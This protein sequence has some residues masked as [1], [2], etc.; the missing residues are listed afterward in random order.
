MWYWYMF[1]DIEVV[2][3]ARANVN[4]AHN[5]QK[6]EPTPPIHMMCLIQYLTEK[7]VHNVQNNMHKWSPKYHACMHDLDNSVNIW[8]HY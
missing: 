8:S 1:H 3:T 2:E 6:S 7:K 5:V 4:S